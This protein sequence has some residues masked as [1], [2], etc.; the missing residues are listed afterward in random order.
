MKHDE[1]VAAFNRTLEELYDAA[2][3]PADDP[4]RQFKL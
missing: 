3:I 1:L 4:V 2:D